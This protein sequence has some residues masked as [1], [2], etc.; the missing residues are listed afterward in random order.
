MSKYDE[1]IKECKHHGETTFR[2]NSQGKTYCLLCRHKTTIESRY[3]KKIKAIKYKG[4]ECERCGYKKYI[5]VLELHHIDPNTKE[6]DWN[7]MKDKSWESIKKELNKC[8]LLC[9]NCHREV[10]VEI[11]IGCG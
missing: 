3:R 1:L 7:Q 10:H 4:G 2:E 9:A 5:E 6:F 11:K 8:Q